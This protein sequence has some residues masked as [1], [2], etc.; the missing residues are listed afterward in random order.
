MEAK[1]TIKFKIGELRKGKQELIDFNS[2]MGKI[3]YK[4]F[5]NLKNEK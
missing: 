1:K 4:Y 3:L 5:K 2:K